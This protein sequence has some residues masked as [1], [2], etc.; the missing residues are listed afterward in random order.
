MIGQQQLKYQIM[1]QQNA[2]L[3]IVGQLRDMLR[4]QIRVNYNN[5]IHSIILRTN[6]TLTGSVIEL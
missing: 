5:F 6:R 2:H 4:I 1:N 3:R